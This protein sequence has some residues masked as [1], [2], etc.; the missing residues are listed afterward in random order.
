MKDLHRALASNARVSGWTPTHRI[1]FYHSTYDTVVPYENL[2]SFIRHQKGLNYY[3]HNRQRSQNANVNPTHIVEEKKADV[4]IYDDDTKKDHVD[5][6]K[7]FYFFGSPSP[8][9][10]LMKWVVEGKEAGSPSPASSD[11]KLVTITLQNGDKTVSAEALISGSYSL[12]LGNGQNAC[13]SQYT[14]GAIT[15]PG[16]V[17]IG[18]TEYDVTVNQLAFRLCNKLTE[19][20]VGEGVTWIG[21][22]AF[23]GCSS[24]QKVSLPSTSM[25]NSA[26]FKAAH[27]KDIF[28]L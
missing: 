27:V 16:K 17:T 6:G 24:L 9:Y 2:L 4:Y 8:D 13:I 1:G 7:D 3:F 23:V 5:A 14:E 12:L 21:D 25:V 26:S 22:F 11:D 18:G 28:S 20:T 15:I 10:K 19:V